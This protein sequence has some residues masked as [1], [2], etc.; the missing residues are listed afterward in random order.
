MPKSIFLSQKVTKNSQFVVDLKSEQLI[1]VIFKIW[2]SNAQILR[3]KVKRSVVIN[4]IRTKML[5]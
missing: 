2:I 4:K 5:I 3:D 1:K